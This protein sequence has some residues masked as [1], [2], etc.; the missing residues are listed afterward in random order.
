MAEHQLAELGMRVQFSLSAPICQGGCW[1]PNE[2]HNL[3][4]T[5]S[6]PVPATKYVVCS[7]MVTRQF[8][9]L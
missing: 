6:I 5:G 9:A 7:V 3:G 4:Y 8:V 2:A 1:F